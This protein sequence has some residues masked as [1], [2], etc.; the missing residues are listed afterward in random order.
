[1]FVPILKARLRVVEEDMGNLNLFNIDSY[2]V[3]LHF[4]TSRLFFGQGRRGL[5]VY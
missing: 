1:M 2:L 4:F 5:N 3:T